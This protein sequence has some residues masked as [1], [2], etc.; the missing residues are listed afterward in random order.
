MYKELQDKVI[1]DYKVII[2]TDSKC[3]SRTHAHCND[4]TR[5]VCKWK[6][7]ES[8]PATLELFHEI[9][10][11][12]TDKSGMKRAE[13]ESEATIWGINKMKEF[14]LPIKRKYANQYKDYVRM[15]FD[16]GVRRG[17]KKNIK[18]KLYM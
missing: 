10:H 1:Q 7:V 11:L 13:Q 4:G 18:S 8:Y 2:V 15:T 16:R 12:E 6:Q 17:L 5:R 14:G 9:G 3:W